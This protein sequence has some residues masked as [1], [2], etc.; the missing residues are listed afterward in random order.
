MRLTDE[1][2]RYKYCVNWA[3][4]DMTESMRCY[5]SK[6]MAWRWIMDMELVHGMEVPVRSEDGYCG[7]AGKPEE[8]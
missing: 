8:P 2:A 3:A 6:C 5:G 7:L 4:N 1:E